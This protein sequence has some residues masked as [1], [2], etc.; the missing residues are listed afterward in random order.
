[1][2]SPTQDFLEVKDVRE[3]IL[4]LKNN[5]IRGVMMVSST[6]FALQSEEDQSAVLYAFQSF[7]NSLDFPCQI[8]AQSRRINITPYLNSLRKLQETQTNELLKIQT[9]SYIEFIKE[10]IQGDSVMT[11][12]FYV[13]IPYSLAGVLGTKAIAKELNVTKYF[14]KKKQEPQGPE[15]SDEDF[16]RYKS[17][18]W[19]RM[20]FVALGLRRCGLESAPLTTPELIELLWAIHH[21]AEAEI[22]YSPEIL[23]ELLK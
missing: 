18:L 1:M 22:G 7:L 2:D 21:P 8:T 5:D 11:K 14:G 16:E 10:L 15:I 20:E 6:N 3:G 13:I 17:Q 12:S 9:T 19:Q 23:P 4:I